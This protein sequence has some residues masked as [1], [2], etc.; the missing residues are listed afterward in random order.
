MLIFQTKYIIGRISPYIEFSDGCGHMTERFE[1]AQ[2]FETTE[3]VEQEIE[4][5]DEDAKDGIKVIPVEITC[6]L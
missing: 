3:S 4:K 1:D 6:R 2:M 5:W